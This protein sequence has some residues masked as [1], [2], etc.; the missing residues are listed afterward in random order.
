MPRN[1]TVPEPLI[2][3]FPKLLSFSVVVSATIV[4]PL[5]LPV[6]MTAGL[7]GWA[8]SAKKATEPEASIAGDMPKLPKIPPAPLA[9]VVSA[10]LC[11]LKTPCTEAGSTG[12]E[13]DSAGI[14]ECRKGAEL[15]EALTGIVRDIG[16]CCGSGRSA[17]G[18]RSRQHDTTG[19]S[20]RS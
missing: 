18:V 7:P 8:R 4:N 11:D 1:T 19:E 3:A 10:P 6:K 17:R 15:G 16:V 5:P 12:F 2:A 14:V 13:C 9:M 20:H